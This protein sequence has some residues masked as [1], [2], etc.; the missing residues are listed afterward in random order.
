M[1]KPFVTV[2]LMAALVVASAASA[3]DLSRYS[4]EGLRKELA[5]IAESD[6]AVLV[7]MRDGV[8]L[9][10][11]IWRPKGATGKLPTVLWKTP[12]NEHKV[13]G[14]TARYAIEA[15][16]RGYAFIVQNERGRYFSQGDYE[17]LGYPRTDGYDALS[18]IAEQ[19]WSNGK[20]GTLGCSSSAEWQLALASRAELTVRAWLNNAMLGPIDTSYQLLNHSA[21]TPQPIESSYRPPVFHAGSPG[22]R[23]I[24]A[25]KVA[26]GSSS[27]D[28]SPAYGR[29][30][31][32]SCQSTSGF[33]ASRSLYCATR[34][35]I[36]PV[37]SCGSCAR[38]G[39]STPYIHT[40]NKV[41]GTPPV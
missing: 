16:R 17:I 31:M 6:T 9:S 1:K 30:R 36:S 39:L 15:V 5:A 10:T 27:D 29:W 22:P 2:L 35:R 19:P 18:W 34:A 25:S 20:V 33:S 21:G 3:Q 23:A 28:S 37:R 13:R 7:P 26:A 12:Y 11:N 24:S 8:G 14:S 41:R 40:A 38:S 4:E 32:C